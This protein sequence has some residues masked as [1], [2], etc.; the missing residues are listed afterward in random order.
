MNIP[1]ISHDQWG[2]HFDL[3]PSFGYYDNGR[4]AFQLYM[5]HGEPFATISVNL[6]NDRITHETQMFV[7]NYAENE[8][9]V[10]TLI[11]AGWI[12]LEGGNLRSGFVDVPVGRLAGPLL[13]WYNTLSKEEV[14]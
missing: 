11:E 8:E 6:P 7:K 1:H 4:L 12:V 13:D 2:E 5:P 3:I 10:K 9:I 14:Q